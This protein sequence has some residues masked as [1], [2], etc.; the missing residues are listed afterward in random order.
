MD[1]GQ[2]PDFIWK[3]FRK[4]ESAL[5]GRQF[6][7]SVDADG[8]AVAGRTGPDRH[9]Q[10]GVLGAQ[11]S[12][13]PRPSRRPAPFVD[14]HEEQLAMIPSRTSSSSGARAMRRAATISVRASAASSTSTTPHILYHRPQRGTASLASIRRQLE[15]VRIQARGLATAAGEHACSLGNQGQRRRFGS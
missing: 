15:N 12:S 14:T 5:S 8:R 11:L 10:C 13:V 4:C 3:K 2:C 7:F 1:R 6:V 9:T